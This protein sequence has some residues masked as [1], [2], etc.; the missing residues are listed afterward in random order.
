MTGTGGISI[1]GGDL[2]AAAEQSAR[3]TVAVTFSDDPALLDFL[4]QFPLGILVTFKLTLVFLPAYIAIIGFDQLSG[5]LGPKSIRYLTV[6]ARRSSILIG[7]YLAQETVLLALTFVIDLGLLIYARV[8]L[9]GFTTGTLLWQLGRLVLASMVF[10]LAY[11]ALT[12]LCSAV[13][14]QPVVS[15]VMNF[16]FLPPIWLLAKVPGLIWIEDVRGIGSAPVEHVVKSRWAYLR[17]GSP[18]AYVDDL[19]HPELGRL[20]VSVGAHLAYA[21]LFLGIA[22]AV[23]R[24]RDL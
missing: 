1:G 15:L 4:V 23:L 18:W 3:A 24:R 9:E 13:F 16:L 22:Y 5:E 11:A 12:S 2:A 19:L 21:A 14:R 20:A 6:R 8:K 7:K 17:Y 10:S